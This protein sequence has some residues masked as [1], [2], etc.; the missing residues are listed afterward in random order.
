MVKPRSPAILATACHSFTSLVSSEYD[1]EVISENQHDSHA[2]QPIISDSMTATMTSNM[3]ALGQPEPKL[4]GDSGTET[5][6]NYQG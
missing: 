1:G 4:I 3:T 5:N 2:K 6:G